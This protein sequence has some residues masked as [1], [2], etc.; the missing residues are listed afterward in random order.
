MG[1][2]YC[3]LFEENFGTLQ[4]V[5]CSSK[6]VSSP[7]TVRWLSAVPTFFLSHSTYVF[8]THL[9]VNPGHTHACVFATPKYVLDGLH[10]AWILSRPHFFPPAV[11]LC[12][13]SKPSIHTAKSTV[14]YPGIPSMHGKEHPSVHIVSGGQVSRYRVRTG[15]FWASSPGVGGS[16]TPSL[17]PPFVTKH[18]G[19]CLND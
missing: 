11:Q 10:G 17:P 16:K 14:M 1:R 3:W 2:V 7:P 8:W 19:L 4:C 5:R 12:A 18:N 9:Q 13:E 6:F 15:V